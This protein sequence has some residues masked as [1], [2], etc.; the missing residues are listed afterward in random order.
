M[1]K[2]WC[3]QINDAFFRQWTDLIVRNEKIGS[4]HK[5]LQPNLYIRIFPDGMILYSIRSFPASAPAYSQIKS[6]STLSLIKRRMLSIY[7]QSM[8]CPWK[9]KIYRE[10]PLKYFLILSV[11][12]KPKIF[13]NFLLHLWDPLIRARPQPRYS[14][15]NFQLL[16][17]F[18]SSYWRKN[19]LHYKNI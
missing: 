9:Y 12:L 16:T 2:N 18:W 10:G 1:Y 19:L 8:T 4:F 13:Q 17:T 14:D 5:I 15:S 11:F 7:Y 3:S 6:L